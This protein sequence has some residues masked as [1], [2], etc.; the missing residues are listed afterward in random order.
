[1]TLYRTM[2]AV[3]ALAL[4]PLSTPVQANPY[5]TSMRDY[6]E[7]EV[8]IWAFDPVVIDAIRS[9]NERLGQLPQ[10]RIDALDQE[11]RAQVGTGT[12]PLVDEVLSHPASDFLRQ[13]AHDTAGA[14]SEIFL[15]DANGLNVAATGAT[16]DYWQ[17]DEEKFTETFAVGPGAV[18]VGD[19]EFDE[20]VQ[21]YLGQISVS[22]MDPDTR[23]VI[24]AVTV[25]L[26]ADMLY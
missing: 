10:E 25:G 13:R 3:S 12:Q 21:A 8:L 2:L 20:S 6:L 11:W 15:M 4:L 22:I 26:N 7:S 14:I 9:Q 23:E 1:M 19:V 16:S 18:H 5:E 24:G 17:G